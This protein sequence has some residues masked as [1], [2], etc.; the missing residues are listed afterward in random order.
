MSDLII[1]VLGQK[2]S[3]ELP[4]KW[5]GSAKISG[6]IGAVPEMAKATPAGPLLQHGH[7][8]H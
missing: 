6:K 5:P 1:P 8:P 2:S 7:S 4:R 3:R